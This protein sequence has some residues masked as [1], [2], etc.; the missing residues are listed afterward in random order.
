MGGTN[1][2]N[3]YAREGSLVTLFRMQQKS[4]TEI[5]TMASAPLIMPRPRATT[6][7]APASALHDVDAT[8]CELCGRAVERGIARLVA[9]FEHMPDLFLHQADLQGGLYNILQ[10]EKALVTPYLTQDG[11]QTVLLHRE[12]PAVFADEIGA[13][14][15]R[16]YDVAV[17]N[18]AFVINHDL[19]LVANPTGQTRAALERQ[20]QGRQMVPLLA[21]VNLRLIEG[22]DAEAHARLEA[23]FDELIHAGADAER[24][25]LGVFIRH[26][27][28]EDHIYKA[29]EVLE[30]WAHR[31]R[32]I[33]LLVVQSYY[34]DVGRVFGGRY[35]NIWSQMA[36]LPPLDPA[37]CVGAAPM[38][39][40]P[41]ASF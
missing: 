6:S 35:L 17:L 26:W 5:N 13:R 29:L 15:P 23:A 33:S 12:Y 7:S 16:A 37:Y 18:P 1:A 32:D 2:A 8:T 30:D 31:Q 38:L 9:H 20:R 25:Y 21:A 39:H 36:P 22:F 4:N 11:R 40:R 28:L 34:D 14:G 19:S 41:Y 3:R 10:G 24:R 27:E